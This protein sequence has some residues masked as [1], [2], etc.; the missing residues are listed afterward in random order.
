MTADTI[1]SEG[2]NDSKWRIDIL[3][4]LAVSYEFPST[5]EIHFINVHDL[6]FFSIIG[7]DQS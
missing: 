4:T 5:S 2:L 1:E 7:T 3:M 6:G